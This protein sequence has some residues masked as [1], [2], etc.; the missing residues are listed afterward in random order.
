LPRSDV[1]AIKL[2]ATLGPGRNAAAMLA[3]TGPPEALVRHAVDAR[4]PHR[5]GVT[6]VGW[7]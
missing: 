5:S 2:R 7:P 6:K 1:L 3:A 4:L